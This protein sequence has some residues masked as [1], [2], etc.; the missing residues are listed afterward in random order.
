MQTFSVMTYKMNFV[1]VDGRNPEKWSNA[2]LMAASNGYSF[3]LNVLVRLVLLRQI[4]SAVSCATVAPALRR[5]RNDFFKSK[6]HI[7]S[8]VRCLRC[9]AIHVRR[10]S[11]IR[12]PHVHFF[13]SRILVLRVLPIS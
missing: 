12:W 4:A 11:G 2:A 13:P 6:S 3:I 7:C 5:R 1:D 8:S 10:S 9:S